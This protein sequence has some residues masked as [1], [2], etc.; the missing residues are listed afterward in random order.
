MALIINGFL[1]FVHRS[2]FEIIREHN[3][4]EVGFVSDF[5]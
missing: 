1:D 4:S 3:D 2:D 5:R